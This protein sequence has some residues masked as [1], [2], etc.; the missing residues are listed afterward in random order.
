M[1]EAFRGGWMARVGVAPVFRMAMRC[2]SL[3]IGFGLIAGSLACEPGATLVVRNTTAEQ[4]YVR[5]LIGSYLVVEPGA[6]V[7]MPIFAPTRRVARIEAHALDRVQLEPREGDSRSAAARLAA[8][9]WRALDQSSLV[10]CQDYAI[11]GPG[12]RVDVVIEAGN[13]GCVD[14]PTPDEGSATIPR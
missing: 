10:F 4:L 5:D 8:G 6:T 11:D 3:L 14:R 2:A 9:E 1:I 12:V 13:I 7:Q